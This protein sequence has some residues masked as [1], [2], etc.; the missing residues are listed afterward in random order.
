MNKIYIKRNDFLRSYMLLSSLAFILLLL[1]AV[2][3]ISCTCSLVGVVARATTIECLHCH[4]T[5]NR[6][7]DEEYSVIILL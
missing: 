6:T 2:H 1:Y 3:F 5:P 7:G 4:C